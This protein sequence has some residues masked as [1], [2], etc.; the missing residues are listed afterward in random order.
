[1]EFVYVMLIEFLVAPFSFKLLRVAKFMEGWQE[2]CTEKPEKANKTLI[3]I[4]KQTYT[5]TLN[6]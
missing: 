5:H 4:Y 6:V 3:K 2:I 1:M